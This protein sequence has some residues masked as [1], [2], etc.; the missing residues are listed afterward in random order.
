MADEKWFVRRPDIRDFANL[1][2]T[3]SSD[4]RQHAADILYLERQVTEARFIHSR[5]LPIKRDF[6]L[7]YFQERTVECE[8]LEPDRFYL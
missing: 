8:E 6:V 3:R 7:V 2:A 5:L 4:F 1:R